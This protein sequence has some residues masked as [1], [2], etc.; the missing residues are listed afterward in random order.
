M[1]SIKG[2]LLDRKKDAFSLQLI[3][4]TTGISKGSHAIIPS[5]SSKIYSL[6]YHGDANALPMY[7]SQVVVPVCLCDTNHIARRRFKKGWNP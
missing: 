4:R 2:G 7:P 6:Y 1:L 3:W 5:T